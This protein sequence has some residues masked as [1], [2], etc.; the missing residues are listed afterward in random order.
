MK[1]TVTKPRGADTLDEQTQSLYLACVATPADEARQCELADRITDIVI[2]DANT[3]A[4]YF[5]NDAIDACRLRLLACIEM[6]CDVFSIRQHPT[7]GRQIPRGVLLSE[8]IK[9]FGPLVAV[10]RGFAEAASRPPFGEAWTRSKSCATSGGRASG[11]DLADC[12]GGI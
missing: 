5:Q 6:I 10:A 9:P 7:S 2:N 3:I 1:H 11:D 4:E 12:P 8:S